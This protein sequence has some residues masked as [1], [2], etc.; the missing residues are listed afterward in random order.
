MKIIFRRFLAR[1]CERV[2]VLFTRWSTWT[3]LE[4]ISQQEIV[5]INMEAEYKACGKRCCPMDEHQS[6][7]PILLRVRI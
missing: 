5:R 1:R 3:G 7:L 6:G 4:W 2:Y